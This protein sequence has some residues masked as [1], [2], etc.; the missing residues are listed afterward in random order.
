MEGK[1]Q[2]ESARIK[3]AFSLALSEMRYGRGC[4]ESNPVFVE[5]QE[6][7]ME[8]RAGTEK[9]FHFEWNIRD[10]DE[11]HI[12]ITNKL[13]DVSDGQFRFTFFSSSSALPRSMLTLIA[14]RMTGLNMTLLQKTGD[15]FV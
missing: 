6:A 12:Y 5:L 14:F 9:H 15:F 10:V 13:N 11:C 7:G 1:V 3:A 4:Q 8:L 2:K